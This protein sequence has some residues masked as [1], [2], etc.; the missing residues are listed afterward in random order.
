[1]SNLRKWWL[2]SLGV[3]VA[4]ISLFTIS[5]AC[6]SKQKDIQIRLQQ[7]A[8]PYSFSFVTW[9]LHALS[10]LPKEILGQENK[11]SQEARLR[12]Q[13]MTVLA[14]NRIT[15]FPPI[16]FRFTNP[17]HLLVV[18]PRDKIVYLDRML[19]RQEMSE[20]DMEKLENS[21][22]ALGLSSLVVELGGFGATYPTMVADSTDI[23]YII[24][25]I[26]EEWFH[27]YL[28][29]KPLG[30]LYLL[31]ST[32]IRRSQDIVTMNETLA[33]MVSKEIS[34]EVYTKYYLGKEPMKSDSHTSGFNFNA[35]MRETRK[36]VD[37]Y[38]SQ[39]NI[40]GAERYTEER[41]KTFAE[42]GYYIRKLN[43][44]YFAFHGVYAHDPA[45]VSPIYEDLKQLRSKGP[46]IRSFIDRVAAMGSY[47]D[48]RKALE[49]QPPN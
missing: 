12:I 23:N 29:F 47:A 41:R 14:D 16:M 45:S 30:F 18:S 40:A 5:T 25:T 17:P 22:D 36:K 19:L 11:A 43:Q 39:R 9:E 48:L 37:W 33:D 3:S 24:S 21:V 32:G 42:H 15:V 26:V 44:A 31:D 4:L 2:F 46:P 8:Q 34:S 20:I 6:I 28:A 35:E 49:D 38:L 1:M 27:Q 13:I 10:A 7:I